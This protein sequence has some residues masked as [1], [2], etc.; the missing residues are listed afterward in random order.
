M[1]NHAALSKL[2]GD[3][4]TSLLTMQ[5]GQRETHGRERQSCGIDDTLTAYVTSA[6]VIES[7]TTTRPWYRRRRRRWSEPPSTQSTQ[8]TSNALFLSQ[9][10]IYGLNFK[11]T[12]SLRLRMM[13]RRY[14][15][16]VPTFFSI[17]TFWKYRNSKFHSN[18]MSLS[19]PSTLIEDISVFFRRHKMH[20]NRLN[21]PRPYLDIGLRYP[22]QSTVQMVCRR[23]A[24]D[25]AVSTRSPGWSTQTS[26]C[27]H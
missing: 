9:S 16:V 20:I 2:S 14:K 7:I 10:I 22:M 21:H 24:L 19:I 25:F 23:T 3:C 5:C 18:G 17:F 26:I 1:H 6:E 11:E 12:R 15:V 13:R 4:I 8:C 27:C